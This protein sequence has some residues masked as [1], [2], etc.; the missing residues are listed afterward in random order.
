MSEITVEREGWLCWSWQAWGILRRAQE[1]RHLVILPTG[2]PTTVGNGYALTRRG[3]RRKAQRE[4]RRW[5]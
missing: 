5:T 3:A 4:L 2:Q 1:T